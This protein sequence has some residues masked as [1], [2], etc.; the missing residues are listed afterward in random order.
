MTERAELTMCLRGGEQIARMRRSRPHVPET[1]PVP[2]SSRGRL[3]AAAMVVLFVIDC[4]T[5]DAR[6]VPLIEDVTKQIQKVSSAYDDQNGGIEA[7]EELYKLRAGGSACALSDEILE[8]ISESEEKMSKTQTPDDDLVFAKFRYVQARWLEYFCNTEQEPRILYESAANLVE[9]VATMARDSGQNDL[10]PWELP[11]DAI[12]RHGQILQK[13]LPQRDNLKQASDTFNKSIG[14]YLLAASYAHPDA[15]FQLGELYSGNLHSEIR[16]L[17]NLYSQYRDEDMADRWYFESASLGN[18]EARE[19]LKGRQKDLNME[20]EGR[21]KWIITMGTAFYVAQDTL[22]TAAH[23][24]DG[25]G[26][27]G[28]YES[29][30]SVRVE[31]V[32]L[33]HHADLAVL[34]VEQSAEDHQHVAPLGCAA[35][36]GDRVLA[37]GFPLV[38]WDENYWSIHPHVTGGVVSN[39]KGYYGRNTTFLFSGPTAPGQSGGPILDENFRV[40]GVVSRQIDNFITNYD[41]RVKKNETTNLN[42][43]VSINNVHALLETSCDESGSSLKLDEIKGSIRPLHRSIRSIPFIDGDRPLD[44]LLVQRQK[45]WIA[46]KKGLDKLKETMSQIAE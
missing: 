36:S 22:L 24:V 9:H 23:V 33:D 34:K 17:Q 18:L 4:P 21:W 38:Y 41:I 3:F 40:V 12:Y 29:G 13:S 45:R 39:E 25:S 14:R 19:V 15:Q 31:V 11:I 20:E 5:L 7:L 2:A 30:R 16:S 37:L 28:L 32:E 46:I 1:D 6:E 35:K 43:A 27:F 8:G 26:E 44:D 10:I 42:E